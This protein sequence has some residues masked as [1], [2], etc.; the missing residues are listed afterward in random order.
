MVAI[1]EQKLDNVERSLQKYLQTN[2]TLTPIEWPDG[3]FSES[4]V[5]VWIRPDLIVGNG[6]YF[7]QVNGTGNLLGKNLVMIFN[8]NC[9]ANRAVINS[10]GRP[11]NLPAVIDALFELFKETTQIT[12]K[13]YVGGTANDIGV[14]DCMETKIETLPET[15]ELYQ[16]NFSVDCT[17]LQK[18]N[19]PY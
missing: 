7:R 14:V 18:W 17:Y 10:T 3:E 8:I 1:P 2:Y 19:S 12:V 16:K 11:N 4:G 5:P 13:D 9:F 6:P 15:P